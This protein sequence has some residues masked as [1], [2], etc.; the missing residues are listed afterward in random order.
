MS[1]PSNEDFGPLLYLAH[2]G[3]Q[4]WGRPSA[5]AAAALESAT[6]EIRA[7]GRTNNN[8]IRLEVFEVRLPSH[9]T[10]WQLSAL[11]GPKNDLTTDSLLSELRAGGER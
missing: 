5:T 8:L 11:L 6:E 10:S 7:R 9:I 3:G 1:R 2:S 4:R